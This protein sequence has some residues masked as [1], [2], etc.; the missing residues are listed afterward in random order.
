MFHLNDTSNHPIRNGMPQNVYDDP[1]FFEGYRKLR[2]DDVGLNGAL[3]IPALRALLPDLTGLRVLDLGCGFGDFARHARDRGARSVTAVDVSENMI[4]EAQ[5]LTGDG[6]IVYLH[7]PIEDF[8]P[9]PESFDLVVSSLA[10]HY[11]DDYAAVT[12]RVFA[13]LA[14]GGR[15]LFSVEHP[16]CTAYPAGW[17]RDPD[18]TCL[19][20][21]LDRYQQEGE[22]R[23]SWFI[24]GV[25]KFHRTVETY[26]NTLIAEG[27]RLDHLG[28]PTPPAEFLRERPWLEETLKRPPFLLLAATKP[29]RSRQS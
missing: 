21:P 10:L 26:V 27:F 14:D 6:N 7:C 3:E 13:G 18:G 24:D 16:A 15:F 2:Q 25:V 28:E 11:I 17:V 22:R 9:E 4:A 8:S 19:Y 5:R 12:K 23:T 1:I 20:W 29:D